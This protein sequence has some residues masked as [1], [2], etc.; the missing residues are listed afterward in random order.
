MAG[1]GSD[2]NR[3]VAD[4]LAAAGAPDGGFLVLPGEQPAVGHLGAAC[5]CLGADHPAGVPGTDEY[6]RCEEERWRRPTGECGGGPLLNCQSSIA[7]YTPKRRGTECNP[8]V[9]AGKGLVTG[10]SV[11]SQGR[12]V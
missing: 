12:S 5:R 3:G 9:R 2:G 4:R 10:V 11:A 8:T 7:V 6:P 1:D